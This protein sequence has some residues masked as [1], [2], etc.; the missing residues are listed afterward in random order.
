MLRSD[1]ACSDAAQVA[2]PAEVAPNTQLQPANAQLLPNP[3]TALVPA[4]GRRINGLDISKLGIP[5]N[6]L[7]DLYY[8]SSD[9]G[10]SVA[11]A[12]V[13]DTGKRIK[14]GELVP[15]QDAFPAVRVGYSTVEVADVVK[16]AMQK[17]HEQREA[18]MK[19]AARHAQYLEEERRDNLA[20]RA[21]LRHGLRLLEECPPAFQWTFQAFDEVL[22][23]PTVQ[24]DFC[25]LGDLIARDRARLPTLIAIDQA[26]S[27]TFADGYY[28]SDYAQ[29]F[30]DREYMLKKTG[31]A[32]DFVRGYFRHPT[33]DESMHIWAHLVSLSGVDIYKP[34]F[35]QAIRDLA[36]GQLAIYSGND[37]PWQIA[38]PSL[39]GPTTLVVQMQGV[40][41]EIAHYYRPM[42]VF[43]PCEMCCVAD[44]SEHR[45]LCSRRDGDDY[46][47]R[48][49]ERQP[50]GLQCGRGCKHGCHVG[51]GQDIV[52]Y[53]PQQVQG[54]L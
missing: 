24:D 33:T 54:F 3:S 18:A 26:Y 36:T 49:Q 43:H 40:R 12:V 30:G 38:L 23:L 16:M 19:R 21:S 10:S 52:S 6:R 29:F 47:A 35:E 14:L 4:N 48:V 8:Q 46:C 41:A 50:L 15:R 53:S 32:V 13:R 22:Q 34:I 1:T 17:D 31:H 2:E 20:I 45:R 25:Q 5:K 42:P 9:T 39:H 51:R 44:S 27:S 37:P 7:G 11:Y 28:K